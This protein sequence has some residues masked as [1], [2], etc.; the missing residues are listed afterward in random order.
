[1]SASRAPKHEGSAVSSNAVCANDAKGAIAAMPATPPAA[2]L[3][4]P[5]KTPPVNLALRFL[6]RHFARLHS[7][8]NIHPQPFQAVG[9]CALTKS[10]RTTTR[11]RSPAARDKLP[12]LRNTRRFPAC[13]RCYT[14]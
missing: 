9:L 5:Q 6:T 8:A 2:N 13:P 3:E 14:V 10:Y 4:F 7:G 11:E 1:M 12:D